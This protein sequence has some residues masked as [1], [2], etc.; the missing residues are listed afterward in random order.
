MRFRVHL[1]RLQRIPCGFRRR[2]AASLVIGIVVDCPIEDIACR[3]IC[4][5][6]H[7]LS[8]PLQSLHFALERSFQ[9]VRG[10]P[11]FI[12]ELPDL[13]GNLRVRRTRVRLED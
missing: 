7:G 11:E 2:Q 8:F 9:I 5:L 1:L 4:D 10:A 6:A 12:H 13:A 3:Y